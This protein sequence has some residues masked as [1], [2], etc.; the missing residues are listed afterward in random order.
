MSLLH[1]DSSQSET[2]FVFWLTSKSPRLPDQNLFHLG[3]VLLNVV[4]SCSIMSVHLFSFPSMCA[5]IQAIHNFFKTRLT[6]FVTDTVD[7]PTSSEKCVRLRHTVGRS[8]G[9][10]GRGGR[11]QKRG[12]DFGSRGQDNKRQKPNDGETDQPFDSRG[13]NGWPADRPKF[14]Q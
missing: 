10:G 9:G 14:L 11:F 6:F 2:A 1:V 7:G 5:H 4:Q 3:S 8:G 13:S 12:R